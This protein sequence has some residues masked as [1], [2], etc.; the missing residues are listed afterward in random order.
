MNSESR[1]HQLKVL[2]NLFEA[3]NTHA[4]SVAAFWAEAR[5]GSTK[6]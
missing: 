3:E 4:V 6:K 5:S 1:G 2:D